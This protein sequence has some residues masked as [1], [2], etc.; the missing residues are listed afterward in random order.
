MKYLR[1]RWVHEHED[2]PIELLSEIDQGGFE[3]RKVEIY[4]DGHRDYAE[5]SRST[6]TTMLGENAL[7]SLEDIAA[8]AEFMPE[9]IDAATFERAWRQATSG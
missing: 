6:G 3:V 7:P 8:Q 9:Y 4:R 5:E 1:V 2:E